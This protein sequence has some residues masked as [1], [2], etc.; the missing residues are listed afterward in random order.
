MNGH[1]LSRE[2]KENQRGHKG[3]SKGS[4]TIEYVIMTGKHLS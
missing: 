4:D 2:S 1:R 3:E